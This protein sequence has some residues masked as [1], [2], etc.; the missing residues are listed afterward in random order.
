MHAAM[1]THIRT[2]LPYIHTY[3]YTCTHAYIHTYIHT[4]IYTYIYTCARL[5]TDI[6]TYISETIYICK[7]HVHY[8]VPSTARQVCKYVPGVYRDVQ[9]NKYSVAIGTWKYS[10]KQIL[11]YT[12]VYFGELASFAN[13]TWCPV[14]D[15]I[16]SSPLRLQGSVHVGVDFCDAAFQQIFMPVSSPSIVRYEIGHLSPALCILVFCCTK[17]L[18]A[19]VHDHLVVGTKVHLCWVCGCLGFQLSSRCCV[20]CRWLAGLDFTKSP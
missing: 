1:Q 17:A 14:G 13:S 2:Y 8:Y 20:N 15:G 18:L 6:L 12:Y 19:V 11:L 3:T 7:V 5:P 4:Y 10:H 9:T 16:H